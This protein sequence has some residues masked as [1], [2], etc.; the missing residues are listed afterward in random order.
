MDHK[1]FV[2]GNSFMCGDKEYRCTDKGTRVVVAIRV[3][4]VEVA[5]GDIDVPVWGAYSFTA[6]KPR[7]LNKAEAEAEGWFD[8][9][10]YAVLERVFDEND[11]PACKPT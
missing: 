4:E 8:G 7:L 3:D 1:N 6:R 11:F 2:I 10:P 9:P 5:G